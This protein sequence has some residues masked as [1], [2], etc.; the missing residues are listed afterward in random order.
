M[1]PTQYQGTY[2]YNKHDIAILILDGFIEFWPHVAPIC[3]N[4]NSTGEHLEPGMI[5]K[6]AGWGYSESTG[7][8]SE[9][10]KSVEVPLVSKQ[11]CLEKASEDFRPYIT[12]DKLCAG[13]GDG[14]GVC[15]GDSGASL[16]FKSRVD[17]GPSYYLWGI[18]SNGP[19]KTTGIGGCDLT[20]F[21]LYTNVQHYIHF[22]SE[23]KI[24]YP[25]L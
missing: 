3:L 6:V 1:K 24:D 15:K 19:Q 9:T 16:V 22:I 21:T 20:F 23:A 12:E 17:S 18:V 8:P 25:S 11:E 7:H 14:V 10:L 13:F 5:G 2:N 4:M